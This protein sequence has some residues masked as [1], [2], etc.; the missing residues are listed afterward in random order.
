MVEACQNRCKVSPSAQQMKMHV[1]RGSVA[2]K[3]ALSTQHKP[4]QSKDRPGQGAKIT[5]AREDRRPSTAHKEC[6][7]DWIVVTEA[8]QIPKGVPAATSW[9][10]TIWLAPPNRIRDKQTVWKRA[11]PTFH[12]QNAKHQPE[13]NDAD[14]QRQLFTDA[15]LKFLPA[16]SVLWV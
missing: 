3:I 14:L 12:A 9:A 7:A 4:H 16:G 13:R 6:A 15:G 11:E 5:A 1:R 2:E 10:N 8:K